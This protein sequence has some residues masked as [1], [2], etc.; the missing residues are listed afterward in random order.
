MTQVVRAFP[1]VPGKE[2]AARDFAAQLG[3]ARRLAATAFFNQFGVKSE[4]WHL[5][6]TPQGAFV[7]VVTEL[8]APPGVLVQVQAQ[9]Y[10][11]AQGPFE[12]W[13]KDNVR[14]V[15]GVDPD[16]QPLGPPTEAIFSWNGA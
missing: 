14:E 16:T 15:S 7:I 2:K 11:K 12:R 8:T 13:F 4:S 10:A 9:S 3:G 5:Q 1:I 6:E